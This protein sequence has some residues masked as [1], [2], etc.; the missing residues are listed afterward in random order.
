MI[1]IHN[2]CFRYI[3]DLNSLA[4]YPDDSDSENEEGL[5]E[6]LAGAIGH[7]FTG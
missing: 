1:V 2:L 6:K 4:G 3:L 7:L 5:L